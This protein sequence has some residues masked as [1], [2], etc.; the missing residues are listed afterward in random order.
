MNQWLLDALSVL[1]WAFLVSIPVSY[2]VYLF[3]AAA[4]H[5]T[6]ARATAERARSSIRF[7][8]IWGMWFALP[9]VVI[10]AISSYD[11]GL[12][13]A[14]VLLLVTSVACYGVAIQA[15]RGARLPLP[16]TWLPLGVVFGTV[17]VYPA[18]N[19]K[20]IGEYLGALLVY[21]FAGVGLAAWLTVTINFALSVL[22]DARH[23]STQVAEPVAEQLVTQS[24]AF[25][26]HTG[27]NRPGRARVLLKRQ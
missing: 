22:N 11:T 18:V 23:R 24:I 3:W 14:A 25:W 4:R 5:D 1:G 21:T 10:G 20:T 16:L 7:H 13:W 9:L 15:M 2:V 6:R 19:S 27:G 8:S 26:P 12:D 17:V